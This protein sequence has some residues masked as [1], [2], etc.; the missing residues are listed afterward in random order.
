M[1]VTYNGTV[2]EFDASEMPQDGQSLVAKMDHDRDTMGNENKGSA[3]SHEG[4][5]RSSPPPLPRRQDTTKNGEK[6]CPP[7]RLFT[8]KLYCVLS[9]E[10]CHRAYSLATP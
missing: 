2:Y 6:K 7:G 10:Q 8:Q 1:K 4:D 9:I 5:E 3:V